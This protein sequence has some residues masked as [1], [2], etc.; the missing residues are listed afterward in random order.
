MGLIERLFSAPPI[1]E[2]LRK[3]ADR[4][5]QHDLIAWADNLVSGLGRDLHSSAPEALHD[6]EEKAVALMVIVEQLRKRS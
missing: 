4:L 3:R 5:G 1:T 6:A 2:P